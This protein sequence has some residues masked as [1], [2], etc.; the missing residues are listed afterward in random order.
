MCVKRLSHSKW[1]LL[2]VAV[3]GIVVTINSSQSLQSRKLTIRADVN[4]NS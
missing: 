4:L 3:V 1:K 2:V